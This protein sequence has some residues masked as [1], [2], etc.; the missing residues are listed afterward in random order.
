MLLKELFY[1]NRQTAEPEDD[2]TYNPK[3]DIKVL[4]HDDTRKTRL[5]LKQINTLRKA[6]DQHIKEKEKELEF[7]ARMYTPAAEPQ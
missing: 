5:T 6:S 1:M 3:E 4:H 7:I 2:T